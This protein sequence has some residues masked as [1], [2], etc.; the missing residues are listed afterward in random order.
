MEEEIDLPS[1]PKEIFIL[2][3]SVFHDAFRTD[4]ETVF[5]QSSKDFFQL[6]FDHSQKGLT[7]I[8]FTSWEVFSALSET[9][10]GK[11][12]GF[13]VL[14]GKIV[15]VD[16]KNTELKLEMSIVRL[17]SITPKEAIDFYS[18]GMRY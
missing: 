18:Q 2:H 3:P 7:R 12:S 15:E 14:F 11:T 13:L 5:K 6:L 1:I 4:Y 8:A 10:L 9:D 17:A 16:L